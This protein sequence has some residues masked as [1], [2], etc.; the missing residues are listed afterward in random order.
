MVN[1]LGDAV[2]AGIVYHLS[3]KQL[4]DLEEVHDNSA[5]AVHDDTKL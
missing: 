1:V 3:R 5:V 4:Q 2:G